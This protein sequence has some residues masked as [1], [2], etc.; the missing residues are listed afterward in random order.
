MAAADFFDITIKGHGSHGAAPNLS[1]DPIVAA[2]ALV[3]SLQTIVSRNANL[4]EAAVLSITQIH[5]GSAHN[6]IPDE[7][8]L[9]G[10]ARAFSDK[11]RTLHSRA[12]V[13]YRL[14]DRGGLWRRNRHSKPRH[15]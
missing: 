8:K 6:V 2:A 7:V 3:Q 1:R 5:G 4:I 9:P 15:L 12:H 14:R 10:T 13:R 11:I